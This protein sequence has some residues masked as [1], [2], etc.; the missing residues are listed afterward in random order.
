MAL[1]D[2]IPSLDKTKRWRLGSLITEA[3]SARPQILSATG[4]TRAE[5]VHHTGDAGAH[6]AVAINPEQER[7]AVWAAV[8]VVIELAPELVKQSGTGSSGP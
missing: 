4:L 6:H 3:R 7:S 8:Q 1:E 2:T 5:V